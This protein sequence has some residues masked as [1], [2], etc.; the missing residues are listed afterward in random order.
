MIQSV[1]S[2]FVGDL[3]ARIWGSLVAVLPDLMR[4]NKQPALQKNKPKI[5][6]LALKEQFTQK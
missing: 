2:R 6:D 3:G 4:G 5:R 1:F